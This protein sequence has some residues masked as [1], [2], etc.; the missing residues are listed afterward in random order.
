MRQCVHSTGMAQSL[1]TGP[2]PE[3]P[4]P[5]S[6]PPRCGDRNPRQPPVPGPHCLREHQPVCSQPLPWQMS[7]GSAHEEVGVTGARVSANTC[8]CSQT[9]PPRAAPRTPTL[10]HGG[11]AAGAR[12]AGGGSHVNFHMSGAATRHWLGERS[13]PR[14]KLLAGSRAAEKGESDWSRCGRPWWGRTQRDTG[15]P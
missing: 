3:P 13:P 8:V 2:R 1:D 7:V 9:Y 5:R 11:R 10:A 15:G 14:C 4:R 6:L 12:P